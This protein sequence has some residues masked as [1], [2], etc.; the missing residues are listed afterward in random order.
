MDITKQREDT[1]AEDLGIETKSGSASLRV[2]RFMNF[3]T[4]N[5]D[6]IVIND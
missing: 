3:L 5:S 6:L 2:E 4:Y 1:L